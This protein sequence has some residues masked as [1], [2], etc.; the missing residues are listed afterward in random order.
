M[1]AQ[2]F[3][4][5]RDYDLDSLSKPRRPLP[6]GQITIRAA[7]EVTIAAA[8]IATVAALLAGIT[9][10][11]LSAISG[12]LSIIY[13]IYA[14]STLLAGNII[15]AALSA[16][17]ISFGLHGKQLKDVKDLFMEVLVLLFILGNEV[18]KTYQDKQT[19]TEF[20]TRTLATR[21]SPAASIRVIQITALL[22]TVAICIQP[23][24]IPGRVLYT[25]VALMAVAVPVMTSAAT[26]TLAPIL[27]PVVL[28]RSHR[29]WK[30][31]WLPGIVV[32]ILL[33]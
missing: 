27:T 33:K 19:D 9:T 31:A 8:L 24:L 21:L 13:S 18:F 28:L 20:G 1:F 4:D 6:S 16:S 25:P 23:L 14:K 26:L 15:V 17:L 7:R 2:V 29:I 3:N 5:I 30:L 32:G 11:A 12:A 10:I 22:I